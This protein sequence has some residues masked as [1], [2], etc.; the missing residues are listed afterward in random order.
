MES[1]SEHSRAV[2]LLRRLVDEV[3][4]LD[5][6]HDLKGEVRK[7]LRDIDP[8]QTDENKAALAEFIADLMHR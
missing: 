6:L 1:Q 3:Y 8:P 5:S 4:C 2:E 7:F